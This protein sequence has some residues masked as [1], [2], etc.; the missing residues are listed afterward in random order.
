[1]FA[2]LCEV[3]EG[4]TYLTTRDIVCMDGVFLRQN[5]NAADCV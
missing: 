1:M 5:I 2:V 4:V 3:C